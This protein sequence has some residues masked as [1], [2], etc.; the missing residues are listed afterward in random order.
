MGGASGGVGGN[1]GA[2]GSVAAGSG[3][4]GGGG[5]FEL[6]NPDFMNMQGCSKDMAS[7]CAVFP[8]DLAYYMMGPNISPELHWTGVPAGTQSFG[9]ILQDLTNG[10]A[11]W[12]IWNIAGTETGVAEDIDKDS[13]MPAVPAG[14]QQTNA[15]F[16]N[17]TTMDGYFGP[18]SA[19]NVYEF[20]LYALSVPKFTPA[21]TT[22]ANAV[23]T[24]L[25]GAGSMLL[26]KASLRG[27][28]NY[29]DMCN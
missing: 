24:A 28:Q 29:N 15:T 19:C 7:S 17:S 23:R 11:H 16:A 14:S 25:E 22:D 8:R 27:R 13:A 2:A 5:T 9:L 3:G 12:A 21:S 4:A 6:T 18:G 1:A 20:L 26:G 10:N